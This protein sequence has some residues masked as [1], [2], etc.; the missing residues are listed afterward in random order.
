MF[1]GGNYSD[2]HVR[3]VGK[4]GR[5]VPAQVSYFGDRQTREIREEIMRV[6]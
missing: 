5:P 2:H 1:R 3:I 6:A 4:N